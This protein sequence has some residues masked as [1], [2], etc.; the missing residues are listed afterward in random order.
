MSI[1]IN[2]KPYYDDDETPTALFP[3]PARTQ[4]TVQAEGLTQVKLFNLLG[5][6]MREIHVNTTNSVDIDTGKLERGV[7]MVEITTVNEVIVKYLIL[8]T[9]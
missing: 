4:V 2:A 7:Y 5:Q 1:V 6:L 8:A 9:Y 3:N